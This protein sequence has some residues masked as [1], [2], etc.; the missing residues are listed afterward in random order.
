MADLPVMAEGINDAA[1]APPLRFLHRDDLS[2]TCR[3]YLG[4]QAIGIRHDQDHPN[5]TTAQRL[6][7]EVAMLRGTKTLPR[8]V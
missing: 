7:T 2:G 3:N 8:P 5:R 6:W 1:Q 4:E